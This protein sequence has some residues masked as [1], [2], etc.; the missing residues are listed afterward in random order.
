[1]LLK[2]FRI[3][4]YKCVYDSGWIEISPLT[5]FVGKN[6]SGKTSLLSALYRFN[7]YKPESYVIEKDWPRSKRKER[8]E[9]QVVC[10][11]R[12]ELSP[13]EIDELSILTGQNLTESHFE[14]TRKYSGILEVDFPPGLFPDKHNSRDVDEICNAIPMIQEPVSNLFREKAQEYINELREFA[15]DG[16]F[17]EI[18]K[19]FN[20]KVTELRAVATKDSPGSLESKNEETFIYNYASQISIISRKLSETRT[21]QEKAQEYIINH[22]PNF[23]Y[24]SDYQIFSGSAD[25]QK[26][27]QDRDQDRLSEEEKTLLTIMELAGLS[28]EEE[29][30]KENSPH[31]DERQY[32]LDDASIAFTKVIADRWKQR[33]Y[34]VQFRSDGHWFYTF[35]KDERD[36][37]LIRLEE[38]SKGFQWFFSFDLMFMN[39]SKGTFRNC[40][41]LL[42]EPGLHLHPEAQQDLI[43]RMEEYSKNNILIYTTHLPL[44][45]DLDKP[46]SIRILREEGHGTVVSEDFRQCRPDEKLVLDAAL[47]MNTVGF[48]QVA[49]QNLVLPGIDDYWIMNELSRLW[50]RSGERSLPEDVYLFAAGNMAEAIYA[51]VMMVGRKLEVMTIL[52]S[53]A[54][55]NTAKHKYEKNWMPRLGISRSNVITLA[56]SIGAGERDFWIEDLFPSDY[57]LSKVQEVYKKQLAIVGC[58]QINP[59]GSGPLA[60]RVAAALEKYEIRFEKSLVVKAIHSEISRMNNI[61]Q[62]P[63]LTRE[64]GRKLIDTINGYFGREK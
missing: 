59:A 56:E 42:D 39:E 30:A 57:Y 25:L 44:M 22:L 13:E 14:V 46:E 27:I 23:I 63:E 43:R 12:F 36:Q 17:S 32:D 52:N 37:A 34:E 28:L 60:K 64:M 55:S 3:Q 48:Y 40:V 9:N 62:L 2:A 35:V 54:S 21:T 29:I 8:D 11:T 6:E 4:M 5:A 50:L 51:T 47:T 20:A 45:L 33:R 19:M 24:M 38:R 16:R 41:I 10:S 49:A 15:Y 26:V 7:P 53:D 18:V 58:E 61:S 1:M 31:K